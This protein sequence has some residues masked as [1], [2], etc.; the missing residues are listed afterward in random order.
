MPFLSLFFSLIWGSVSWPSRHLRQGMV[1]SG[2]VPSYSSRKASTIEL[3]RRIGT[4]WP[5]LMA[6][7]SPFISVDGIW[8]SSIMP[9]RLY[10]N[11]KIS[12]IRLQVRE[13][14]KA[15]SARYV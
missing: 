11:Q 3:K 4:I 6:F 12:N 5:K 9:N 10:T 13:L 7:S 2:Y 14:I 15:I 1:Q 8:R